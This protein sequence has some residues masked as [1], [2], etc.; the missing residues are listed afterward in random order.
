MHRQIIEDAYFVGGAR[1]PPSTVPYRGL[2]L[3]QETQ[4]G[5]NNNPDGSGKLSQLTR[6]GLVSALRKQTILD[7]SEA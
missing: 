6:R 2:A 4:V 7:K 5:H 3:K 1:F